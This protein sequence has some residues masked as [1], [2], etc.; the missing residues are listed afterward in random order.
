[1]GFSHKSVLLEESIS[2]LAIRPN[3]IYID[4]TAGGGGHSLEIAKRLDPS[5]GRLLALDKDPDAVAAA[6]ERLKAYPCAQVIQSDFS[7]IPQ[8]LDH[9]GVNQADGIL[10]DLGVSS[11][12]LDTPERG[13][14]YHSDAPLD[15]RMSQSGFSA[16]ELVNQW[17]V[18]ELARIFREYGEERYAFP[19]AKNIVRTREKKPISTTGEL[20]EMIASSIPAAARREGGHP[21]KRTFQ[22]IRI[23][24]NGELDSLSQCLDSAFERLSAGGRFCI[25][26]FHSLE[27][28]MVKQKFADFAKGCVCPPDFPVCVCGQKPRAALITKKPITPSAEE[29]E[30]NSRSHSA[31]L[32]I[33]ERLADKQ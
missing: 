27:D 20:A 15:M 3:G 6:S 17:E 21:A 32:R 19:I 23:A 31:H 7:Q 9:L 5:S 16:Y 29:L 4:G 26:T 1:M 28:R 33:V 24:V 22:A 2:G 11:H 13:F 18:G 25:I 30:K 14:S 8:V 12:Q 10:L